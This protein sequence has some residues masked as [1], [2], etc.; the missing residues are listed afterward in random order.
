MEINIIGALIGFAGAIIAYLQYRDKAKAKIELTRLQA[1]IETE[2]NDTQIQL[3]LI[4]LLRHNTQVAGA[5][6]TSI[7]V[8]TQVLRELV[9]QENSTQTLLVQHQHAQSAQVGRVEEA[10]A[11]ASET[12]TH[13]SANGEL[14]RTQIAQAIKTGNKALLIQLEYIR[15]EIES[16]SKQI[17]QGQISPE[18]AREMADCM[19]TLKKLIKQ[20]VNGEI[21]PQAGEETRDDNAEKEE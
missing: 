17:V 13:V 10:I 19:V 15:Q 7:D 4:D 6:A 11:K 1:Q 5:T 12:M 14:Q 18:L 9:S 3:T 20:P 8:N 2:R 21:A 16:L